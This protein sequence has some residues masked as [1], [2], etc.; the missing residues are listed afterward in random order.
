MYLEFQSQSCTAWFATQIQ[1]HGIGDWGTGFRRWNALGTWPI[2]SFADQVLNK[3]AMAA[4]EKYT[5]TLEYVGDLDVF[6]TEMHCA[7][8][9]LNHCS[10]REACS[11]LN[12]LQHMC[13]LADRVSPSPRHHL[14]LSSTERQEG[15]LQILGRCSASIW[16]SLFSGK[17][18]VCYW[19][20]P[21]FIRRP[22][23]N[24]P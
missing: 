4:H 6:V 11:V 22:S 23:I 16:S 2:R 19:W 9:T 17:I 10:L 12:C 14:R 18:T 21:S 7:L 13:E 3:L 20:L 8:N 1:E 15:Q 5:E 24:G